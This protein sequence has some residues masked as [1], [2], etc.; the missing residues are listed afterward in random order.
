MPN[1]ITP[2]GYN[3]L[4]PFA[5][6]KKDFIC[7]KAYPAPAVNY[8]ATSSV[9]SYIFNSE[10]LANEETAHYYFY[11]PKDSIQ[12]QIT[13]TYSEMEGK[14]I[15]VFNDVKDLGVGAAR[16]LQHG[17]G[18]VIGG[19]GRN[20]LS[21]RPTYFA[22]TEKRK[23]NINLNLYLT[24]DIRTDI[25][26]PILFLK[27]YS[28]AT[29]MNTYKPFN[30]LE[31]EIKKIPLIGETVTAGIEKLSTIVSGASLSFQQ[32]K[33]PSLFKLSGGVFNESSLGMRTK[34]PSQY[35]VLLDMTIDYNPEIK[36]RDEH[37]FPVEA[38][39]SLT[40]EEISTRF[41][42]DFRL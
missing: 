32:I 34:A 13:H 3:T 15:D 40:F 4:F 23:F 9:D 35:M 25:Y 21:E 7:I 22:H 12:E 28:H 1:H 18:A 6:L 30:M 36:F 8:L 27:Y 26:L 39:V 33:F 24:S 5:D 11:Y 19:A 10:E 2:S 31:E 17:A 14:L 38:K 29:K 41:R 42:E 20:I 37:G 16:F